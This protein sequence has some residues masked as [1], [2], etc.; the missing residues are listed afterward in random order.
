MGA[1][2]PVW[3]H[4]GATCGGWVTVTGRGSG[5]KPVSLMIQELQE[6][7]SGELQML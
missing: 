6:E 2:G 5:G 4:Q 7:R 3:C 1:Q